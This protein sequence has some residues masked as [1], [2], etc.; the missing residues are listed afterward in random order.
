MRIFYAVVKTV[1]FCWLLLLPIIA[2]LLP[3]FW[4]VWR[5]SLEN[6]GAG[7]VWFAVAVCVARGLPVVVNSL[8]QSAAPRESGR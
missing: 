6:I 4:A 3:G 7:L 5:T 8:H 2:R 1:A